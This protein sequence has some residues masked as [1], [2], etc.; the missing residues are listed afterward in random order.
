MSNN[1][2][3]SNLARAMLERGDKQIWCAIAD[4]SDE[5]AMTAHDSNDF[6]AHIVSFKDGSFYCTGGMPWSYAVPIEISE[7]IQ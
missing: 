7:I 6:T 5:Q 1:L 3:G 2:R 4:D